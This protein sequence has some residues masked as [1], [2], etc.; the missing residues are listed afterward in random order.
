MDVEQREREAA[1]PA[2]GPA[3]QGEA[4]GDGPERR[5]AIL[6]AALEL[7]AERGFHGTAVPLVAE[8]AGVAAGTIY[9]YF[10]SKEDLVN[11]L[12]RTCKRR[13]LEELEGVLTSDLPA[14]QR[15][16]ALWEGMARAAGAHS[17]ALAFMEL[18]HHAPYLD[19]ESR[20]VAAETQS[21]LVAFVRRAQEEG[22]AKPLPPELLIALVWGAF[23]SLT[24][25][26]WESGTP[27]T[28]QL[29][30]AREQCIWEV[31]WA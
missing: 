17:K 26:C 9:R 10:E 18:H 15:F 21:R 31:V 27:L 29:V 25:A 28:P 1:G 30:A 22:A 23:V 4:L 2:A 6:G 24:R 3:G 20:A 5:A 14:R 19:A 12:Y 16:R 7:F 13:M 11:V 8:R